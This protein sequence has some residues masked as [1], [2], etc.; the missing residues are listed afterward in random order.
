M[1]RIR[2]KIQN[3]SIEG[4]QEEREAYLFVQAYDSIQ[5][6]QSNIYR[7]YRTKETNKGYNKEDFIF[8]NYCDFGRT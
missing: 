5:P 3:S 6:Q 2:Y 1:H 7:I 4:K 8:N